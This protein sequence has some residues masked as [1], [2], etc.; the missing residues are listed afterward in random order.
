MTPALSIVIPT[1]NRSRQ[2]EACLRLLAAQTASPERYE[3]VVV[4]DG[5]EDDTQDVLARLKTPYRLR[6]ERQENQGEAAARNRALELVA[7]HICLFIDDD[8]LAEPGLVEAHIRAHAAG[9]VVGIGHL[10]L[11]MAAKRRGGLMRQF[12]VSWNEHYEALGAGRTQPTFEDC[13]SGNLSVPTELTRNVGGFDAT[14]PRS[15][16]IELG[17]RLQRAGVP[18][19]YLPD[20][21]AAQ[22]YEKGL[23]ALL[24]DFDAGGL[25]A[26]TLWRRHPELLSLPPLGDFGQTGRA[27]LLLRR[28]MLALRAPVWPLVRVDRW[29]APSLRLYRFVQLY[30]FWRS[31]RRE[32]ADRTTWRRIVRG[33]VILMYHAVG[34]R[35]EPASRFVIPRWRLAMQLAWLRVGR[36]PVL[37]LDQY[38]E[39][40]ESARLV[41]AR[42]VVLTFDDGYR[43]NYELAFPLLRRLRLRAAFFVVSGL[44]GASNRW[45]HQ[46]PLG[47]RPLLNWDEV[48]ALQQ[49]GMIIGSHTATHA[50]LP[51][52]SDEEATHELSESRAELGRQ[53]GRAPDHFC[54]PYGARSDRLQETVRRLGYR[55]ALSVTPGPNGPAVDC[56]ALRRLEVHGDRGLASFVI[57]LWLGIPLRGPRRMAGTG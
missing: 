49:G 13:Y 51:Q 5:S 55:S 8:I 43:D 46:P 9:P 34:G 56:Y 3:V 16:D 29:L 14:L 12:E 31:V 2:L 18:L 32:L 28:L 36:H 41:P 19:R 57:E 15:C 42:S 10:S 44:T 40:Q 21:S 22:R 33:P 20:A 26:V 30:C 45:D 23:E 27:A 25:A 11:E 7:G 54:F 6:F 37:T 47:D 24:R 48:R 52:L 53:L 35:G 1:Y 17:L 50:A 4:D 38:V 39:A